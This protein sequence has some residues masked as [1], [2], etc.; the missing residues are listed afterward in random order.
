MDLK[1]VT[2]VEELK[3]E[4]GSVLLVR[5]NDKMSLPDQ[6]RLTASVKRVC[7]QAG[8]EF[9]TLPDGVAV[10][11]LT[12]LQADQFLLWLKERATPKKG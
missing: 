10:E 1:N 6:M 11:H 7:D 9:L 4:R 12:P 2:S 8:A 5:Y 3:V